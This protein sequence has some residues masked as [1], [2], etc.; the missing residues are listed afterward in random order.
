[1][2]DV[3]PD[4]HSRDPVHQNMNI[5]IRPVNLPDLLG[6]PI[7]RQHLSPGREMA[8]ELREKTGVMFGPH[9]AKIRHLGD[10]PQ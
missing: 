10:F 9:F 1:M 2:G 4:A 8:E 3:G 5:A 6:K 7:F